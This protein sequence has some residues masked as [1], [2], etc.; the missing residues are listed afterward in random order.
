MLA[1]ARRGRGWSLR[2]AARRTGCTAGTVVHLEAGRRAPSVA[3]AENIIG[4]YRLDD[5]Q[6]RMLL[7]EAV[8]GA[9]KSSPHK[10]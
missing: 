2:E 10:R 5:G 8:D 3:L 1:D 7:A 4:A 9:G 6:A